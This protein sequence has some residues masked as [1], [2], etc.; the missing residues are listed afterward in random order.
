MKRD[1]YGRF[2]KVQNIEIPLPSPISFIKYA[3][4]LLIFLPWIYLMLYKFDFLNQVE[5][6]M[7]SLFGE[8]CQQKCSCPTQNNPY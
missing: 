2:S 7:I 3:I 6:G 5:N 8:K 4:L 1:T